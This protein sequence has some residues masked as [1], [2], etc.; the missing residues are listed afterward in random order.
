MFVNKQYSIK[1]HL[2]NVRV[3]F[4]DV[5]VPA[6]G[7]LQDF[8]LET[9]SVST[10]YPFGWE[11]EPLSWAFET[12]AFGYQGQEKDDELK[13]KSVMLNYKY[14][15]YDSRVARFFAVDPLAAKYPYNS[16]YA[17]SE[18]KVIRYKELEGSEVNDPMLN[19]EFFMSKLILTNFYDVKHSIINS[20]TY[21][22]WRLKP[23]F[24]PKRTKAVYATDENGNEIF[25]TQY[26]TTK[27]SK[28]DITQH[29][30]GALDNLNV[31]GGGKFDATD[32]LSLNA[33][34]KPMAQQFKRFADNVFK[35]KFDNFD[36]VVD[37]KKYETFK[38][39]YDT[40]RQLNIPERIGPFRELGKKVAK[41]LGWKES[42]KLFKLNNKKYDIFTHDDYDVIISIDKQ[43]G[44]FEFFNKKGI[45]EGS[46]RFDGSKHK[47]I[48]EHK[49]KVK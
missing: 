40:M 19:D 48:K 14:R 23:G 11:I 1:D 47:H 46:I 33:K 30:E 42:D 17:F 9:Q 41:Y 27:E 2:G 43:H 10:Y 6:N 3:T 13:G 34:N 24:S 22:A 28:F 36:I 5:K 26:I 4:A 44:D 25:K 31:Y 21:V 45:H 15:A 20:F 7:L 32:L 39:F 37:G 18:N 16:T 29:I 35:G 12:F 8:V 38:D 49:L